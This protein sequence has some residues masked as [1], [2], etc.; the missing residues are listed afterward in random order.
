MCLFLVMNLNS[1]KKKGEKLKK[2]LGSEFETLSNEGLSFHK[3]VEVATF[4]VADVLPSPII[5]LRRFASRFHSDCYRCYHRL[6]QLVEIIY[7]FLITRSFRYPFAAFPNVSLD[8]KNIF[9]YKLLDVHRNIF[10]R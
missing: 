9:P 7:Q 1:L 2:H 3:Y 6:N 10:Q 4:T 5:L 8:Y